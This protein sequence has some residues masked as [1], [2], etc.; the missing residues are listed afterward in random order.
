ML[1]ASGNQRRGAGPDWQSVAPEEPVDISW[2]P[3]LIRPAE[4]VTSLYGKPDLL[5]KAQFQA[6][7]QREQARWHR[8]MSR[9]TI[10]ASKRCAHSTAGST[11]WKPGDARG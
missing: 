8:P 3:E 6:S 2:V 9:R 7:V 4:R 11:G 1:G 5:D 10:F